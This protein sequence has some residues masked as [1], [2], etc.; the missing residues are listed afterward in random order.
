MH[1]VVPLPYSWYWSRLIYLV[2]FFLCVWTHSCGWCVDINFLYPLPVLTP[3]LYSSF[4]CVVFTIL[5]YF[6]ATTAIISLIIFLSMSSSSFIPTIISSP[7]NYLNTLRCFG[8][9]IPQP[10]ILYV[11][12]Y[13]TSTS[14][15]SIWSFYFNKPLYSL[16][17]LILMFS[18]SS[19]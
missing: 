4:L 2:V 19:P 3:S 13:S 16:F 9:F 8:F 17:F 12:K 11:G 18:H 14:P 10:H 15:W 7:L 6:D 5:S 1:L